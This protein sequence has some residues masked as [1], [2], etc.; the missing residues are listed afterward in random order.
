M[1]PFK[2]YYPPDSPEQLPLFIV[3]YSYLNFYSPIYELS[4]AL[5]T[6]AFLFLMGLLDGARTLR[7]AYEAFF[8]S[9]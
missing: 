3:Y 4:L 6:L 2:V 8:K 5:K 1:S 9:Y 7:D